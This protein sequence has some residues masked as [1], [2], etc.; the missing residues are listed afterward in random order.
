MTLYPG[1]TRLWK[2]IEPVTASGHLKYLTN[3][4]IGLVYEI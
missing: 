1:D 4:L 2:D 3:V